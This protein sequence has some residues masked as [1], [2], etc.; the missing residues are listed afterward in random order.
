[1][2]TVDAVPAHLA[3]AAVERRLGSP[4]RTFQLGLSDGSRV[5]VGVSTRS[6]T[7]GV[8]GFAPIADAWRTSARSSPWSGPAWEADDRPGRGQARFDDLG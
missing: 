5:V 8:E 1:M 7:S 6:Q 2:S 3:R 4:L